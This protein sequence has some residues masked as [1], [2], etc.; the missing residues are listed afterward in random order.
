MTPAPCR[1]HARSER[2]DR[3]QSALGRRPQTLKHLSEPL[4]RNDARAPI[5]APRSRDPWLGSANRRIRQ[6]FTLR[7][8]PGIQ[9]MIISRHR[10]CCPLRSKLDR[11]ALAALASRPAER[12]TLRDDDHTVEAAP[13]ARRGSTW[14]SWFATL[15]EKQIARCPS[16]HAPWRRRSASTLTMSNE[17]PKPFVWAQNC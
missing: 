9:V 11:T 13:D 16:Q 6:G 2:P 12:R 15:T 3:S 17:A 1:S 8:H 4:P 14:W 10:P 5:H 7:P